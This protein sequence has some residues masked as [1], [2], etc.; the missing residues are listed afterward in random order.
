MI[1]FSKNMK[2]RII[3]TL[4]LAAIIS[5]ICLIDCLATSLYWQH[6][7]VVHNAATFEADSWGWVSF[8]WNDTSFAQ[9][10]FQDSSVVEKKMEK[11]FQKKLDTLGIK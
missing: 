1:K 6:L 11:E 3:Q 4:T 10:P 2:H 7:A 9:A 5:C 8:K